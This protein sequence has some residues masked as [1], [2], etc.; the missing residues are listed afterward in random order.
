MAEEELFPFWGGGGGGGFRSEA[1]AILFFTYGIGIEAQKL[2]DHTV[3]IGGWSLILDKKM[4]FLS[5]RILSFSF[6]TNYPKSFLCE[7]ER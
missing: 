1:S 5:I 6:L 4:Y 3:S 7:L 2:S